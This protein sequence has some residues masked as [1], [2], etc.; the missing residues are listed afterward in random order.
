MV[1]ELP[2]SKEIS[3][4]LFALAAYETGADEKLELLCFTKHKYQ[5]QISENLIHYFNNI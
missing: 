2:I 1:G 5:L 3:Q 4:F